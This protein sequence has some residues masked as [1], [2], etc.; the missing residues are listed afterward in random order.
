MGLHGYM[1][2]EGIKANIQVRRQHMRK[3]PVWGFYLLEVDI[4]SHAVPCRWISGLIFN[5]QLLW[6]MLIGQ[7]KVVCKSWISGRRQAGLM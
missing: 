7:R 1:C 3:P 6:L 4:L 5:T 2:E